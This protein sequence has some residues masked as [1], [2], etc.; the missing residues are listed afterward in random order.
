MKTYLV[1]GAV[2]DQLLGLDV[3]DRDWVVVGATPETMIELGFRPVGSDFPV[4]LHPD[5]H[6]EYALARTERKSGKGYKGFTFHTDPSVTLEEDLRRRDLTINAI[7]LG[8]DGV[9]E[10]PYQGRADLELGIIRHVSKAFIE[11]P[12]RVLRVAR[13]QARFAHLNFTVAEQTLELMRSIA[14]SGE[15]NHLTPER[16]W[17]EFERALNTET[18]SAFFDTLTSSHALHLLTEFS[19][20]T[21]TALK[22]VN[23][24]TAHTPEVKFA[25]LCALANLEP[26][27]I[28]ALCQRLRIPNRYRDLALTQ[29]RHGHTVAHFST[30]TPCEK[31]A[32]ILEQKLTKQPAKLDTLIAINAALNPSLIISASPIR[33]AIAA[34]ADVQPKQL[35]EEGFKGAELGKALRERQLER[36]I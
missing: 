34:V 32:L 27:A 17:Q 11:D 30:A 35:I 25:L 16:V 19:S 6:E 3:K 15:L 4:F 29:Q 13:F 22:K 33:N 24:K 14:Q 36:L 9:Y 2:R 26:A 12:L 10:D 28:D 8:D 31:L 20:I 5:T 7:A 23:A 21:P 18:P 1:G